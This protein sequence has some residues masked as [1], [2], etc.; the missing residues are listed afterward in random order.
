MRRIQR[1]IVPILMLLPFVNAAGLNAQGGGLCPVD[2]QGFLPPRLALGDAGEIR[3]DGVPNR[4]RETPALDGHYL[5]DIQPGSRFTLIAGPACADGVVWWRV[6]ADGRVGWTAES[7]TADR[8]Y[9]LQGAENGVVFDALA[10]GSRPAITRDNLDSLSALPYPD[11]LPGGFDSAAFANL[12]VVADRRDAFSVYHAGNPFEALVSV[13]VEGV[14]RRVAVSSA[15]SLVAA[16]T[17]DVETQAERVTLYR[18]D[19]RANPDLQPLG[20][21]FDLGDEPP[22]TALAISPPYLI[23]AHGEDDAGR[24]IVWDIE[25]GEEHGRIELP[26]APEALL[27]D[28]T[29]LGALV[30]T[31]EAD[32]ETHLL[33]LEALEDV[34]SAPEHGALALSRAAGSALGQLLIGEADGA[35]AVYNVLA[36]DAALPDRIRSGRL[37]R[38]GR[39][40]VFP[41]LDDVPV[42]VTALAVDPTGQLAAIGSGLIDVDETPED[43]TG[44]IAFLDLATG[45][46][47]AASVRDEVFGSF[48]ALGFSADGQALIAGYTDSDGVPRIGVYGA[49]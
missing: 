31:S 44:R 20:D 48:Y 46:V 18:Y 47:S 8:T 24:V 17:T 43:Y 15:A 49:G 3:A 11:L 23:T 6:D 40:E 26:F 41:A 39:V 42:A 19:P 7:N 27:V 30:S 29:G 21:P 32:G 14:L 36:D 10:P 2:Y 12:L 16:A 13:S 34:A 28:T 1:L 4:V 25:A 38:L 9:Y 35:V 33:D 22:L 5:F 37:E 45:L